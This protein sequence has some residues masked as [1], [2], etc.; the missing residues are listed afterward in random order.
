MELKEFIEEALLDIVNGVKN[1]QQKA[2]ESGAIIS[3]R[4]INGHNDAR[5]NNKDHAWHFVNFNIVLT[6]GQDKENKKGI[7]VFLPYIA[8]G[9]TAKNNFQTTVATTISFSIPLIYPCID[10]N[11]TAY[12]TKPKDI[13]TD[14]L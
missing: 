12:K 3:P 7:G 13:V 10:N 11:N 1:A 4:H 8:A 2:T 14:Y 9:T 5:I 6:A